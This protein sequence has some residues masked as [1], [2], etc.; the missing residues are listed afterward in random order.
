MFAAFARLFAALSNVFS[1]V[2][3]S[4]SALNRLAVYADESAEHVTNK[5]RLERHAE[6]ESV[7]DQLKLIDNTTV[8]NTQQAA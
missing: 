3:N 7:R 6:L 4:A 5:A 1:T 8:D 2:E